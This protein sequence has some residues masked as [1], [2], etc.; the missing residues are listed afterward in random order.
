MKEFLYFKENTE[1]YMHAGYKARADALA[2]FEK[3]GGKGIDFF[4]KPMNNAFVKVWHLLGLMR[5]LRRMKKGDILFLQSQT[6]LVG[7]VIRKIKKREVRVVLLIHDIDGLRYSN[8]VSLERELFL[9]RNCDVII[10]HNNAMME[11]L[12]SMGI[13]R[14]CM[15]NL[16]IFDYLCEKP[17]KPKTRH[18]ICFAGNLSKSAFLRKLPSDILDYGMRLYGPNPDNCELDKRAVY[19]GSFPPEDVQNRISDCKYALVWDGDSC[20]TCDGFTGEYMKLNNPHK[21]SLYM[22]AG[23]PV[24]VWDKA[25]I[26]EFVRKNGLGI[27]VASLDDVAVKVRGISPELYQN[28]LENVKKVGENVRDGYYLGNAVKKAFEILGIV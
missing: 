25:A 21:L 13:E 10:V 4:E 22:A 7:K 26:A 17:E 14:S 2:I 9:M 16:G 24:I 11:K 20:E 18:G 12:V 27:C 6:R 5:I 8:P 19:E 3:N 23:V 1:K 15:I 28:F